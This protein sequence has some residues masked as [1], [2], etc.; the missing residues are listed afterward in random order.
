MAAGM[1]RASPSAEVRTCALA[2]EIAEA[3]AAAGSACAAGRW[4]PVAPGAYSVLDM[5]CHAVGV[6]MVPAGERLV[7]SNMLAGR[8]TVPVGCMVPPLCVMALITNI[9]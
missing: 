7:G 9:N 8:R 6:R 2:S 4:G 1:Q 5:A 3:S